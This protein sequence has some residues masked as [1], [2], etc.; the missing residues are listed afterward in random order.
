MS[1]IALKILVQNGQTDNV[2]PWA[3]VGAKIEASSL[4]VHLYRLLSMEKFIS[5]KGDWDGNTFDL[6]FVSSDKIRV[7]YKRDFSQKYLWYQCKATVCLWSQV[8]LSSKLIHLE[9]KTLFVAW[10]ISI[11]AKT[12]AQLTHCN[13]P[14]L[15]NQNSYTLP[16]L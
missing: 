11:C 10:Y 14:E 12:K 3:P 4:S 16:S 1:L 7:S 13:A 9:I 5:S 15:T 8:S 2:T 6:F